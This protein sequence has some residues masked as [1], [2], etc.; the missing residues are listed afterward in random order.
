M[1]LQD[2]Q[3]EEG[4]SD[5]RTTIRSV[6]VGSE[7]DFY[8]YA[9]V[10]KDGNPSGFSIDLIKAV[11]DVMGINI[12]IST[13]TWDE[14]WKML[15]KGQIDLLP[16]VAKISGRAPLVDFSLTHTETF[17]AFFVRKGNP[18]IKNIAQATGKE[19]V[20]MRSDAAEHELIE[21]NFQGRLT[22]VN[23]INEGLLLIASGKHDAFLCSKLIGTLEIKMK[24]IKNLSV[25]PPIP[26]YKRVF[27]F[28][29]KKG[30]TEL[31]EKL[32]QGL[33][34]I[35]TDG[36]YQRIYQKWLSVEDPW[37]KFEKYLLPAVIVVSGIILLSGLWLVILQMEISERKRLEK[38]LQFRAEQ[39]FEVN[40]DLES[41][42]YSIAHDLRSPLSAL[43]GF[44]RILYEDYGENI[45]KEG[46]GYLNRIKTSSEKMNEM[47]DNMLSLSKITQQEISIADVDIAALSNAI[48]TDLRESN[49]GRKINVSIQQN[50]H[51]QADE[52]LL[53][54]ALQNLLKNAWKFTEKTPDPQ[55]EVGS[56]EKDDKRIYFV[57]DNGAGFNP[58]F[59][60]KLFK[61]FKRLHSESEFP[62]T[63]VGLAIVERVIRKH[64]GKI[65]AEGEEGN[66]ATFYFTLS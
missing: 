14:V 52:K 22:P 23:T 10:D 26:D 64:A 59:S 65:W 7:I 58:K 8:P 43:A 21:R 47:I 57:K 15:I 16:I 46:K 56:L 18:S 17:D 66:G 49:P 51:A 36:E 20:V 6:R 42:S 12:I 35:K 53:K 25:G 48:I 63:G 5:Q 9:F 33:L 27:S 39:L 2:A 34:I 44:A 13:G 11:A 19:I 62:G 41:F 38:Q 55:I 30:D 4:V 24:K 3:C 40:K 37:R 54:L 31:L 1:I 61:P 60:E 45:N 28:A 29:V 32:N 50:L